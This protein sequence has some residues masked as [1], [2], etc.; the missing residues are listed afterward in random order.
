MSDNETASREAVRH[1]IS[2]GHRRIAHIAGTAQAW[3][4]S[5]RRAGY[6]AA[7]EDAGIP[8][9]A[10][11]VVDGMYLEDT[12]CSAAGKLLRE[13]PEITGIFSASDV[14]AMGVFQAAREA[15]RKVGEDLA[16][17]GFDD[18]V[19]APL[20]SPSLT[21]FRQNF[22]GMGLKSAEMLHTLI[23]GSGE[24][25]T[26]VVPHELIIRE[27]SGHQRPPRFDAS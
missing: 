10:A 8:R 7:L 25:E 19:W 27:S 5:V 15:G 11:L 3:V 1:L 14:M 13:Y 6:H 24:G 18:V 22:H 20:V 12:A 26:A 21:T 2:L 17:V 4:S 23:S 16:V 9:D